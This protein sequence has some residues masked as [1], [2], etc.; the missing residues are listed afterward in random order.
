MNF[1]LLI[2]SYNG[3]ILLSEREVRKMTKAGYKKIGKTYCGGKCTGRY[4]GYWSE[5]LND[6]KRV[7]EKR[8]RRE[9]KAIC[10]DF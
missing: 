9:G 1:A 6:T 5:P 7:L 10:K 2:Y 8:T 4:F 3:A